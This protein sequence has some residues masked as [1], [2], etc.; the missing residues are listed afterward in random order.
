MNIMYF[1]KI[2]IL[3]PQKGLEIPGEWRGGGG[4]GGGDAQ[5]PK[6]LSKCIKLDRNFQRGGG[7]K[8]KSLLWG[9]YG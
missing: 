9:R 7:S 6:K 5:R 1:Q 2:S 3:P 4:G 8:G